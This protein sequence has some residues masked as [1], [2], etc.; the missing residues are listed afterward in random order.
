MHEHQHFSGRR[1]LSPFTEQALCNMTTTQNPDNVHSLA[2]KMYSGIR[3]TKT[4]VSIKSTWKG[5]QNGS[6]PQLTAR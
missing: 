3:G 1:P 5:K 6:K 4:K 2:I